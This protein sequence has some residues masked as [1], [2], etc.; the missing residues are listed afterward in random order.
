VF[1]DDD[2]NSPASKTTMTKRRSLVASHVT[3][4]PADVCP[5][6]L[7]YQASHVPSVT[8]SIVCIQYIY[9]YLTSCY[10][11]G[12]LD[13]IQCSQVSNIYD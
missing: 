3:L 2:D 5:M 10:L 8:V 6:I 12:Q 13:P 11:W 4:I 7:T 1:E 9:K